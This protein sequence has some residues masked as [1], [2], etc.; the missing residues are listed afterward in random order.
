MKVLG[1]LPARGG[2]KGIPRKNIKLLGGKPLLAY[3]VE[4][5]LSTPEITRPVVSTENAEI[6]SIVQGLGIEVIDRPPELA[7]D[8][9]PT[10]PALTHAL[11]VVE[12]EGFRPDAVILTQPT[13]PF[14]KKEHIQEGI[15][16]FAT[17]NFDTVISVYEAPYAYTEDN[18]PA[19]GEGAIKPLFTKRAPRQQRPGTYVENGAVYIMKPE[20]VRAG[21]IFGDRLGRIVMDRRSSLDIDDMNDWELAEFYLQHD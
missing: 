5:Y 19:G 13:S 16:L 7:E 17:G 3:T 2:S 18:P 8:L 15:R 4:T 20:L 12:K 9:S 11:E 14:V 10:E 6:K 1:I 21:K